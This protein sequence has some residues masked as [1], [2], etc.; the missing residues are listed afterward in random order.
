MYDCE[1]FNRNWFTRKVYYTNALGPFKIEMCTIHMILK[2]MK[3]SHK[4]VSSR[5]DDSF[6]HDQAYLSFLFAL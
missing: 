6:G 5:E 4:E 3:I 2:H 1:P